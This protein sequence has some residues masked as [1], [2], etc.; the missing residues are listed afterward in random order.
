MWYEQVVWVGT[1]EEVLWIYC[2]TLYLEKLATTLESREQLLH[3]NCRGSTCHPQSSAYEG[4][5]GVNKIGG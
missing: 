3:S 4:G 5:G 1:I 2:S